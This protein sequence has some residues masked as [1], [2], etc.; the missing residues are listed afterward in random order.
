MT[1]HV[2]AR[3][4]TIPVTAPLPRRATGPRRAR[5]TVLGASGYS[6]QEFVRLA[7]GHPGIEL[8]QLVSRQHAG[9][10]ASEMLVGLGPQRTLVVV[11]PDAALAA[12][13][14]GE[15]DTVVAC[16]PHGAWRE[17]APAFMHPGQAGAS[18]TEPG[19]LRVIDLSSDF[20]DGTDGYAYGQP[21]SR[22]D[23]LYGALRVANPGCYPTAATLALLPAIEQGWIA[24]P[25]MVSAISGVSGAGRSAT[26]RTSFVERDG[27]AELY[28]AGV[29]H[30]HAGEMSRLWQQLGGAP[31][32]VGF[33]PQIVPMAR[34]ILA[35]VHAPLTSAR[36]PEEAHAT[37]AARFA[38]EPFVSVLP[39]G[40]WP[41]TRAVRGSNRCEVAVTT[42]HD[43]TSLLAT[44]AIDNLVKGAAGQAIQ[45]LNLMLG[46]PEATA[47]PVDGQP[48]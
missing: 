24:G 45:N 19:A 39:P 11:S 18:Q 36:T 26:M 13:S 46:W 47:L 33:A 12:V 15:V 37:W 17:L 6:G 42:M 31:L 48:W 7:F 20:R 32:P 27:G 25:V 4:A 43:G 5:V 23:A 29:E 8:V 1:A 14:S 22:R 44:A 3:P 34:G 40:H 28:K 10:P 30:A 21:E 9:R 2:P 16:L 41:D 35:V 38:G